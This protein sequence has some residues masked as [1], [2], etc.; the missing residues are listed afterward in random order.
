MSASRLM[1]HCSAH[2]VMRARRSSLERTQIQLSSGV[3]VRGQKELPVRASEGL[4]SLQL[5]LAARIIRA[6]Y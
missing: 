4:V 2:A 6:V 3:C 1:P 5:F